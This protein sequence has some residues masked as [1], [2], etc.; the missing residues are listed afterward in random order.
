MSDEKDPR[1]TNPSTYFDRPKLQREVHGW[2]LDNLGAGPH[3]VDVDK[4]LAIV[5][6]VPRPDYAPP[7]PPNELRNAAKAL[8]GELYYFEWYQR[9]D[10]QWTFDVPDHPQCDD[11]Y[12]SMKALRAAV[13]ASEV[14]QRTETPLPNKKEHG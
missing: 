9:G 14:A 4:L 1:T 7:K 12:K 3:D 13:L 11:L 8:L 5:A 6:G 10:G 2:L